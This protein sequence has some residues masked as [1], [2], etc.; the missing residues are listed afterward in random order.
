MT[1]AADRWL[2]NVSQSDVRRAQEEKSARRLAAV[3]TIASPIAPTSL[4]APVSLVGEASLVSDA[5]DAILPTSLPA[6]ASLTAPTSLPAP[7]SLLWEAIEQKKGYSKLHHVITDNLLPMLDVY[8][9]VIYLQLYRLS[10]GYGKSS[11]HIS[12]PR[13]SERTNI[14]TTAAQRAIVR[15]TNKGLIVKELSVF[16]KGKEQGSEFS[17]P[18]PAWLTGDTSLTA[19][20]SL[21]GN[22]YIKEYIKDK[23]KKARRDYSE[24]PDCHGTGFIYPNGLNGGV[25]KCKHEKVKA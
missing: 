8:E 21:A 7:T 15:L 16:G 22:T 9:Q 23:S 12:L 20:T 24:C 13:L 6:P 4:P 10:W 5:P 3:N 2:K 1:K 25:A 19:P 14:S 18:F 17:L 11:C